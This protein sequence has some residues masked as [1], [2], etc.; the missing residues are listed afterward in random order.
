MGQLPCTNWF[1]MAPHQATLFELRH[2]LSLQRNAFQSLNPQTFK[3]SGSSGPRFHHGRFA[4]VSGQWQKSILEQPLL[5][6]TNIHK[7]Q[8]KLII[9]DFLMI[10]QCLKKHLQ[11]QKKPL[12]DAKFQKCLFNGNELHFTQVWWNLG[13]APKDICKL[14][15][16]SSVRKQTQW[17]Q[18]VKRDTV[19]TFDDMTSWFCGWKLFFKHTILRTSSFVALFR[20]GSVVGPPGLLWSRRDSLALGGK[21]LDKYSFE[22]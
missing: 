13:P 18:H 11:K 19:S 4:T 1:I 12:S 2:L 20:Q 9:S 17:S 10:S 6:P 5:L 15:N 7:N 3:Q 8:I 21:W 22:Y 14:A 16:V